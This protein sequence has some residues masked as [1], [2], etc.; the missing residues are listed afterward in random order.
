MIYPTHLWCLT[1]CKKWHCTENTVLCKKKPLSPHWEILY[2][3]D[4]NVLLKRTHLNINY[5]KNSEYLMTS[6]N[7]NI[8]ALLSLC[9]E[10]SPVTGKFPSQRP[11]TRSLMFSFICVWINAWVNNREAGDLRRQRVHYDVM[12]LQT[13]RCY[14][15]T[16][17]CILFP[18]HANFHLKMFQTSLV[19]L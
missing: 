7:G 6:S 9:V 1:D 18:L 16:K 19:C 3:Q 14:N 13:K 5:T 17:Y 2:W 11:V 15:L 8:S 10:N 12:Y 4:Y